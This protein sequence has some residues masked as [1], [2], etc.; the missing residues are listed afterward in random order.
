MTSDNTLFP[1]TDHGI[2]RGGPA[3]DDGVPSADLSIPDQRTPDRF[4]AL[5][6][7]R[8]D[9]LLARL[10]APSLDRKLAAGCPPETHRLLAIRAQALVGAGM[11]RPLARAVEELLGERSG[12]P[13]T[14]RR[15]APMRRDRIM[16]ADS[17]LRAMI[18]CLTLP[19][20]V[21]ARGVAMVTSLLRDG[22]GPLYNRNCT[23]D[24]RSI[25]GEAVAALEPSRRLDGSA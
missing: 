23:T 17:E 18:D 20:P 5:P 7:R 19:L 2:R 16:A 12:Q 4:E 24:L 13:Q 25:V 6:V 1:P 22:L 3:G 21:P 9:A 15:H 10:L 8:L 14:R 11:R